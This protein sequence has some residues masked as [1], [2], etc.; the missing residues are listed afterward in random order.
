MFSQRFR[1]MHFA[2]RKGIPERPPAVEGSTLRPVREKC[3]EIDGSGMGLGGRGVAI[4]LGGGENAQTI[5]GKLTRRL[6]ECDCLLG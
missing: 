3:A 1:L 6:R 5:G 2:H 4:I